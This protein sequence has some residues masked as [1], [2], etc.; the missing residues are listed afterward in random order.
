MIARLWLVPREI[1][2]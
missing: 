2:I 1:S